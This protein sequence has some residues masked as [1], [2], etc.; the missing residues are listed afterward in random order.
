MNQSRDWQG[1]FLYA[2]TYNLSSG[3]L[4][5]A[6]LNLTVRVARYGTACCNTAGIIHTVTD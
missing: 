5:S 2:M 4:N 6:P 3:M 1:R